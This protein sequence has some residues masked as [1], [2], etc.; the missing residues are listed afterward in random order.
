MNTVKFELTIH[1]QNDPLIFRKIRI[2]IN[3]VKDKLYFGED[4]SYILPRGSYHIQASIDCLYTSNTVDVVL[5]EENKEVDLY[6]FYKPLYSTKFDTL[7]AAFKFR[8]C[9]LLTFEPV[10][11]VKKLDEPP[12]HKYTTLRLIIPSLVCLFPIVANYLHL[13][14]FKIP[15]LEQFFCVIYPFYYYGRFRAYIRGKSPSYDRYYNLFTASIF[16]IL[17]FLYISTWKL[18][19]SICVFF[20]VLFIIEYLLKKDIKNHIA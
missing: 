4:K 14:P 10:N 3:G 6:L 7:L 13:V 12:I 18:N 20:I 5:N 1:R 19:L 17:T 9:F 8:N 11:T 15:Y 16:L 2:K